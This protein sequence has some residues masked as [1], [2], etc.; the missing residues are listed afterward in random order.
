MRPTLFA[1]LLILPTSSIAAKDRGDPCNNFD[2]IDK[3]SKIVLVDS[4]LLDGKFVGVFQIS[5]AKSGKG[6]QLD[7][8]K[9]SREPEIGDPILSVQFRDLNSKWV[10]FETLAGTFLKGDSPISVGPG[11]SARFRALLFSQ[12]IAQTSGSDF[13]IRLRTNDYKKCL[14]SESFMSDI[15]RPRVVK[16]KPRTGN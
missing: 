1:L 12:E 3:N 6:I 9:G 10:S 2:L 15:Q 11:E 4:E 13:R 14:V 8:W 7:A 5:V 16:L